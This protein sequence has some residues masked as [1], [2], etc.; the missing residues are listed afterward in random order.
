MPHES[1]G[2]DFG[3]VVVLRE[4][5]HTTPG[6]LRDYMKQN[7]AASKYPPVIWL[8]DELPKGPTGK[9]LKREVKAPGWVAAKAG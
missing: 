6:E 5:A 4:G 9:V 3:A 1:L 7:V 2:E 8:V